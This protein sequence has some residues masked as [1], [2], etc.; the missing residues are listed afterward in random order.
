M[1]IANLIPL[2]LWRDLN[3]HLNCDLVDP[4]VCLGLIY[5]PFYSRSSR[6]KLK[7]YSKAEL[8]RLFTSWAVL[9]LFLLAHCARIV[10]GRQ[11]PLRGE[12]TL[13]MV[14]LFFFLCFFYLLFAALPIS[15]NRYQAPWLLLWWNQCHHLTPISYINDK[16]EC[17]TS[18]CLRFMFLAWGHEQKNGGILV[19]LLA[20]AYYLFASRKLPLWTAFFFFFFNSSKAWTARFCI[21][22]NMPSV[23]HTSTAHGSTY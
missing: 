9:Y 2:I 15:R 18:C 13:L 3:Y 14:L 12:I 8:W 23:S 11:Y 10:R 22:L 7:A 20:S 4:N 17:L 19:D 5:T 6:C 21:A 16:G 1:C